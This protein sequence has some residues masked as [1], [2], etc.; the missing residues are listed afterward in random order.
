MVRWF[1]KKRVSPIGLDLGANSVKLVQFSADGRELIEAARWDLSPAKDSSDATQS[2]RWVEA[3]KRVQQNRKFQ[4]R[5]VVVGLTK[6]RLF[7][8]NIRVPTS[9]ES[10]LERVAQQE[11]A[12]RLPFP[13]GESDIR[14]LT[15]A[16]VRQ[17]D[18]LMREVILVACH[19]PMLEEA[20]NA[21]EAARLKP[22]AVDVEPL[23]MMRCNVRQFRRDEDSEQRI[24]FVH[25]GQNKSMVLISQGE[26]VLFV[27]YLQVG[28]QQMDE[29]VGDSLNLGVTDAIALRRNNG[30][31]RSDQQDPELTR[32]ITDALRGV[33]DELAQEL[34]LCI[35]YHSVTF[36]GKPLARMVLGGGEASSGLA[37]AL[38]DR[39]NLKCELSD[40]FRNFSGK[41]GGNRV[42]QW[43]VAVGLAAKPLA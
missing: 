26:R 3:L 18:T 38:E 24:M 23:A 4:G 34:S 33:V 32:G 41:T 27:K 6:E 36:R 1:R 11:A 20:L 10:V 22:V 13:V 19:R 42:G 30:D 35:R 12:S 28:G 15:A 9:D 17:G 37:T 31:R 29:A 7:L 40:P 2:A 5:D 39:L 43:D 21:V 14:Y 16:E 25:V 8:Q